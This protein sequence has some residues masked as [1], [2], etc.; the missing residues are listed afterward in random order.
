[1]N[2]D[3]E[4]ISWQ[5]YLRLDRLLA[6]ENQYPDMPNLA[7]IL[8]QN[9]KLAR[10][11][12][13]NVVKSATQSM[14]QSKSIGEFLLCILF[15]ILSRT[16]WIVWALPTFFWI[17]PYYRYVCSI[18]NHHIPRYQVVAAW[19]VVFVKHD[20]VRFTTK[21]RP[22]GVR[23]TSADLFQIW[24]LLAVPILYRTSLQIPRH[25]RN[26]KKVADQKFNGFLDQVFPMDDIV[27]FCKP[28]DPATTPDEKKKDLKTLQEEAVEELYSNIEI[29]GYDRKLRTQ[30]RKY[31]HDR[32]LYFSS[33]KYKHNVQQRQ[34]ISGYSIIPRFP[35]SFDRQGNPLPP[36]SVKVVTYNDCGT[37][38]DLPELADVSKGTVTSA[39][40]VEVNTV[41]G[42]EQAATTSYDRGTQTDLE[43]LTRASEGALFST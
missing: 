34:P 28:I 31:T 35:T 11:V 12:S 16:A 7:D 1:M 36:T 43:G 30:S 33:S 4:L 40:D 24:F 19:M 14:E 6:E 26:L 10:E 22:A 37:Q 23:W 20:P 39:E 42:S 18:L 29:P 38:T 32:N 17:W 9:E 2:W 27:E 25:L 5:E 15:S 3:E 21:G 8:L 41:P 13:D